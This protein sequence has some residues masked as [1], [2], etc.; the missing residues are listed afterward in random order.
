MKKNIFILGLALA[1]T[2]AFAQD[3]TSK[4][5]ENYLPEAGD[6]AISFDA[7][8]FLN[9]VGGFFSNAG[10]T[11][12]TGNYVGNL[13]W[14]IRGKYFASETMAFRGGLRLNFGGDTYTAM[15]GQSGAAAPSFPAAPAM[16]EDVYKAGG[17][18]IVLS[19][20][21]EMRRGKTR[22]QGYYGGELFIVSGGTK[23]TYTYGNA[24]STTAAYPT[25]NF[26]FVGGNNLVNDPFY[27]LPGRVTESKTSS[28][29][30]GL[31][32]F[33]GA[34]YF[35]F[36]KISLGLEYG[37]GLMMGSGK[38]TRSIETQNGTAVGVVVDE[39]ATKSKSF[40]FDSDINYGTNGQ[41]NIIFHF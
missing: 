30:F 39:T 21:V 22:L 33:I 40:G 8:P 12:P 34:E 26:A 14:H 20:G 23:D 15:V 36:P 1:T 6:I 16:V 32:G 11:A 35:I 19:G 28:F 5:G 9:Y 7:A 17:S 24:M 4:K 25:T 18:N 37:W 38:S 10:G 31:R 27:G 3:L 29:G 2:T 41:L 13:P